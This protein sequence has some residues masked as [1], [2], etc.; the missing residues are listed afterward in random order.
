MTDPE[1]RPLPPMPAAAI[2][3][4]ILLVL[5]GLWMVTDGGPLWLGWG[6]FAV[7]WALL[8]VGT[9]ARG[10]AWGLAIYDA[11]TEARRL[12]AAAADRKAAAA[13]D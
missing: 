10:V 11:A 13:G 12:R 2:L 6:C 8:L 7:G 4:G 3:P 5:V 9:V 1:P